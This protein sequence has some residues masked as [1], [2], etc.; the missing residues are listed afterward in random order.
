MHGSIRYP[1]CVRGCS[2]GP[3]MG[4]G[5]NRKGN[6]HNQLHKH[7]QT[8]FAG[9]TWAR[10]FSHRPDET[11]AAIRGRIHT[12]SLLKTSSGSSTHGALQRTEPHVY[13]Y[14]VQMP[15]RR[16]GGAWHHSN[17][18]VGL[19][20]LMLNSVGLGKLMLRSMFWEMLLTTVHH[21]PWALR[22]FQ[23]RFSVARLLLP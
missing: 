17:N 11:S 22:P 20:K 9:L 19:G 5:L 15:D 1:R 8:S 10:P 18:S 13:G 3:P 4:T 16:L 2:K 23:S 7:T 14:P 6:G 21:K 12:R